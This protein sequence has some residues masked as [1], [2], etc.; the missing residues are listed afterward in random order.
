MLFEQAL[1]QAKV[2]FDIIFDAHLKELS[3]YRVLVLPDQECLSEEQMG[4]IRQYLEKGGGVIATEHTSLYTEWRERRRDFG[5]KDLFRVSAPGWRGARR[6]E[7]LIDSPATRN[8]VGTGRVVYLAEVK[9]AIAAPRL[10]R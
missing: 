10:R 7:S 8:Q 5:L 4:L 2:P 3:K 1:I 9:P 6:A